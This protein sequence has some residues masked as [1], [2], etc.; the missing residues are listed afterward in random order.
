MASLYQYTVIVSQQSCLKTG[1]MCSR[2][3]VLVTRHA[4]VFC[5]ACR[6]WRRL[7]E[8][9]NSSKLQWKQ[10]HRQSLVMAV[11]KEMSFACCRSE[12]VSELLNHM[13]AGD[14]IIDSVVTSGLFVLQTLLEFRRLG[15]VI[16]TSGLFA[17]PGSWRMGTI[18]SWAGWHKMPLNQ[19]LVSLRVV[20]LA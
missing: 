20:L 4:A 5:T 18:H 14:E 12:T 16:W 13:F 19:A 7:S 8:I 9:P 17:G 15:Y 3:P 1:V 11:D 6:C 2:H 10:M